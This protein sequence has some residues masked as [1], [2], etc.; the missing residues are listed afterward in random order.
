MFLRLWFFCCIG[1][2]LSLQA[3]QLEVAVHARSAILMNAETGAILYEK[4]SRISSFPASTTKIATALYV[5]DREKLNLEQTV[6]VS[7]EALKIRPPNGGSDV[8]AYWNGSDGTKMGLVKGE[9]VTLDALLHGLMLSSGNDAA[10]VLAESFAETVPGFME[11]LNGYLCDLGCKD[12][13]FCNPH[14]YHYPDHFT[15]AYDLCL[16]TKKALQIPKFREIV[17]TLSYTKPK[18]NKQP[19]SKLRLFNHLL[20]PG[21]FFYPKAIGVKTGYHSQ[22]LN[23]LVAA[24]KDQG[25]TLIA[26]LL[27]CENKEERY[28]DAIRLFEMA[29]AEEKERARLFSAENL[30][31]KELPGAKSILKSNLEGEVAIEFYPAEKPEC[32]AF[33]Y[34]QPLD[35][36]IQKGQKVGE[37]RVLDQN[38][39]LLQRQ[40]L[41]AQERVEGTFLFRIKR[42]FKGLFRGSSDKT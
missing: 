12:T 35:L 10:N 31:V 11:K 3:K 8:P 22:G 16:M 5:L 25:R 26:V 33:V 40:N 30:F 9:K 27:G 37:V 24:A 17:S 21:R 14:G 2:F 42:F 41:V 38:G 36:P 34:W 29:F 13:H 4:D 1:S 28:R 23:N 6:T 32:K 7:S 18:T 15:T 19:E 39:F 20:T